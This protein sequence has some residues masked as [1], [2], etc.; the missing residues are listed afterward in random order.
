MMGQHGNNVVLTGTDKVMRGE[1]NKAPR[2]S[3]SH[4]GRTATTASTVSSEGTGEPAKIVVADEAQ[5]DLLIKMITK[6]VFTSMRDATKDQ[7]ASKSD[8]SS[9]GE[10]PAI[11]VATLSDMI[12]SSFDN[13]VS[14]KSED[15]LRMML[16]EGL[17]DCGYTTASASINS[18]DRSTSSRSGSASASSKS[19]NSRSGSSRSGSTESGLSGLSVNAAGKGPMDIWHPNFWSNDLPD[20][21]LGDE[22]NTEAEGVAMSDFLKGMKEVGGESSSDD[23]DASACSDITGLTGIFTE[24]QE[25]RRH[26]KVVAPRR[27]PQTDDLGRTV[28]LIV[29]N[30]STAPKKKTIVTY[31]VRFEHVSVREYERILCDNPAVS[32][33]PPI[34]IGWKFNEKRY[35]FEDWEITRGRIRRPSELLLNREKREALARA[36]G[37]SEKDIA[38]AIRDGNKVKTQRRQTINNLGAAKMEE[39]VETAKRKAKKLLFLGRK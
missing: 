35:Q 10:N 39:A 30:K 16:K 21:L 15:N 17:E 1:T 38:A 25:G 18:G 9:Q 36:L 20:E 26:K 4:S 8:G 14:I 3:T 29:S 11:D 12:L 22:A 34:G 6:E 5:N 2:R 33:G 27:A 23:D 28:H 24:Y 13:K 7:Q 19:G 37:Y 32:R 31:N